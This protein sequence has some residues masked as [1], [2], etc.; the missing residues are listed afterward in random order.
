MAM[1]VIDNSENNLIDSKE[2][3]QIWSL[4]NDLNSK[5]DLDDSNETDEKKQDDI[6]LTCNSC[7]GTN[8]ILEDNTYICKDCNSII[9]RFI[10]DTA[11]WR[12]YGQNDSKQSNPTRCGMPTNELLKDFS[13]GSVIGYDNTSKL[14]PKMREISRYA[15]WSATSYK[16]RSLYHVIDNIYIQANN[17]GIPQSII[18]EA[19]T[20]YSQ[21]AELQISRGANR[22]GLIS[23]CLFW[24][25]KR[26]G[27]PRSS[28]E[29]A[30]IFNIN[31]TTMTKGC[32]KFHDLMN[33]NLQCTSASDFII[34]F[35]SNLHLEHEITQLCVR[36][37]AAAEEL[38]IV[39]A[40]SPSSAAAGVIYMVSIICKLNISK[41]DI[42]E[43]SKISFVT[44]NKSYKTLYKYRAE[45]FTHDDIVKYS[46]K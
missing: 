26:N 27:V 44:C 28:K 24:S 3:E 16:E 42:S 22:N 14:S 34:R 31:I 19:K 10:D 23:S 1:N 41:T 8:I 33:L 20:M 39:S 36:V 17:S 15:R 35:C 32:K 2:F 30:K 11:E 18:E 45:L 5:N 37:V 13:L 4:Y 6:V 7:A 46:I 21:I 40:Q 43:A 29:I 38:G 12:Y 9:D 25:C